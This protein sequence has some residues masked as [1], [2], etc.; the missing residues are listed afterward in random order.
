MHLFSCTYDCGSNSLLLVE[1]ERRSCIRNDTPLRDCG[2]DNREGLCPKLCTEGI[3]GLK[4][5]AA[6]K[7]DHRADNGYCDGDD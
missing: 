7:G 2:L 4:I 5:N 6:N 1:A 3:S